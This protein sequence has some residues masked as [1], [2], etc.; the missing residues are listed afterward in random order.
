M[1]EFKDAIPAAGGH[2]EFLFDLQRGLSTRISGSG[3]RAMYLVA[4]SMDGRRLLSE[5]PAAGLGQVMVYPQPSVLTYI[6]S[7][8]QGL[9]GRN[10]PACQKYFRTNHIMGLTFCPYCSKAELGLA[11]VTKEQ[12]KYI[13]AYYDAFM[14]AYTGG[15]STTLSMSDITD[16][17]SAWH[18]SEEKQQVHFKCE[19]KDCHAETDILGRFGFCP[20]CGKTNARTLF[21][22]FIDR[23]LARWTETDKNVT[24][25]NQRAE[26]W[27]DMTIKSLSEF[28]ALAKHLRL[29]LL[30]FP[31]TANRIQEV[32]RLNFQRPVQT[33]EPLRQWFDIGVL[34]WNGNST[35]PPRTISEADLR[36]ITKMIQRRHILMHNGGV[37]DQEYLDLSGDTQ[38]RLGERIRIR[39]NEAKHFVEVVRELGLNLLDNVEDGFMEA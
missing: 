12:S 19:T 27:E 30:S 36:F 10:C 22:G 31:M 33:D 26:V 39:S 18:Y 5:V 35:K 23:T 37:A 38:A 28:E 25:R 8:E 24:D 29:R 14:R 15:V 4:V 17:T 2:I 13:M 34:R 7:D 11:F 1:A 6:Q 20:R 3:F 32:E 9:W 16:Q 21:S